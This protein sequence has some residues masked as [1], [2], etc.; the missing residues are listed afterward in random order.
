VLFLLI[1]VL[2]VCV[3]LISNNLFVLF[4]YLLVLVS[5]SSG[6]VLESLWSRPD[7]PF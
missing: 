5:F 6:L 3:T 4:I 7:L 1:A 2:I